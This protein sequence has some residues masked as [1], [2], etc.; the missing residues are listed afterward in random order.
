MLGLAVTGDEGLE[1]EFIGMDKEEE[2]R[3]ERDE[4]EVEGDDGCFKA[5]GRM[6]LRH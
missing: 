2:E 1:A 5:R 3:K 4:E 6:P